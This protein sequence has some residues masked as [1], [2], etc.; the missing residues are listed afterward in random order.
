[1]AWYYAHYKVF[2]YKGGLFLVIWV[3]SYGKIGLFWGHFGIFRHKTNNKSALLKCSA[4]KGP[5]PGII[6]LF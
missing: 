2:I 1:M 4:W 5:G 3:K 6:S